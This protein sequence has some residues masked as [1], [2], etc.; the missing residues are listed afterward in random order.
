MDDFNKS[1]PKLESGDLL[2]THSV[3]PEQHF[4]QPPARYTE[5]ALVKALEEFGI[6]RPST[7]APVISTIQQRGYVGTEKKSLYPTELGRIV[8]DIM[9]RSF[10]DIVDVEFTAH[11]ESKLD[12]IAQGSAKWSEVIK[13]FYSGF[14]LDVEKAENELEHVKIEPKVSDVPCDKCGRMMVYRQ[15]KYGEFLAC[16]AFRNA[17]I[18]KPLSKRRE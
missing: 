11:V 8:N 4:T 5:A 6:G 17:V 14:A 1:L 2:L 16:R 7:Y 9:K 18:Q 12:E 3:N 10:A 15:S 13:D